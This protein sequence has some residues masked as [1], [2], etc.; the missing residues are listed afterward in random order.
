[1]LVR[2]GFYFFFLWNTLTLHIHRYTYKR[3]GR[4]RNVRL[5]V[6]LK[7]SPLTIE[8][9]TRKM[10]GVRS[11]IVILT[12]GL[13]FLNELKISSRRHN[14]A[15]QLY[16]LRP[17]NDHSIFFK[18][19]VRLLCEMTFT[20]HCCYKNCIVTIFSKSN[21]LAIVGLD[22]LSLT[23][24]WFKTFHWKFCQLFR[25]CFSCFSMKQHPCFHAIKKQHLSDLQRKWN[26]IEA[27]KFMKP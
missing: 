11:L 21:N 1:M 12:V 24:K 17:S 26:V 9:S 19:Q 8:N 16:Q 2:V 10:T 15:L 20:N 6:K 3:Y 22:R 18:M 25:S 23:S 5:K 7:M 27:S 14:T 13:K 4:V